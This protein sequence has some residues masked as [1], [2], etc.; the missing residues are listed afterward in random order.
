MDELRCKMELHFMH[1]E[2]EEGLNYADRYL[3]ILDP[4]DD[5]DLER[6]RDV[7]TR[8]LKTKFIN[9]FIDFLIE[10]DFNFK[11]VWPGKGGVI[12]AY[13]DSGS[14]DSQI[15]RRLVELGADPYSKRQDGNTIMH[16]YSNRERS[17][18]DKELDPFAATIIADQ[19]DI[20]PWLETNAYGAT[21][22]H[23]AVLNGHNGI[24]EAFLQKGADANL[25]GTTPVQGYSHTIEFNQVTPLHLACS[26]G[27]AEAVELLLKFGAD[28]TLKD[29]RGRT[30]CFYAVS[31]P[32]ELFCPSFF[33]VI[34]PVHE[35]RAATIRQLKSI[36]DIDDQGN[37]PL[38]YTL[39]TLEFD[40][41]DYATLLLELGANPQHTD[42]YGFT[43]L[44]AAAEHWHTASMKK[45]VGLGVDLNAQNNRGNTALHLA[46]GNYDEKTARYLIKK[47]ARFDI[48]NN[49]GRSPL[50]IAVEKGMESVLELMI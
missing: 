30:P 19:E 49:E 4:D 34:S 21:P 2:R 20:T 42:N 6:I 36:D 26:M 43:P 18:W 16:S 12:H 13:A 48:V 44:M 22:L 14:R 11:M 50:D 25:A 5:D 3:R 45:L 32:N 28:D 39:S 7:L 17:S 33:Q 41:G 23:L 27:N 31:K 15:F 24:L 8:G 10:R 46:L 29:S 35:K 40:K 38:L 37:T 1:D 47:G 9:E